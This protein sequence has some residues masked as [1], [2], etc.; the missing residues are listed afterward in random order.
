MSHVSSASGTARGGV[1]VT[2]FDDLDFVQSV[3]R[4]RRMAQLEDPSSHTNGRGAGS[5]LEGQ[6]V[7]NRSAAGIAPRPVGGNGAPSPNS[8]ATG[9]GPGVQVHVAGGALLGTSVPTIWEFI[10]P[11]FVLLLQLCNVAFLITP[12]LFQADL[13]FFAGVGGGVVNLWKVGPA[14][15]D[16]L[17]DHDGVAVCRFA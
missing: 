3:K 10:L 11:G 12:S 16:P 15:V 9:S 17:S 5:E 7:S 1:P 6:H 14:Q 2:Q 8:S 4:E 13:I